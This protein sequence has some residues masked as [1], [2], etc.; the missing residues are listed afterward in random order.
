MK[1]CEIL[2]NFGNLAYFMWN[3]REIHLFMFTFSNMLFVVLFTGIL[4]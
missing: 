2:L 3:L 1:L 4:F